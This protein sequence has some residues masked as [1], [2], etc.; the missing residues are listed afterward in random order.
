M[1]VSNTN[2]WRGIIDTLAPRLT[3]TGAA[4]G[5]QLDSETNT[6]RYEI[7][8]VCRAE[9]WSLLEESFDCPG[10]AI[11]PAERTFNNDSI[12]QAQFPELTLLTTM[13]NSYTVWAEDPTPNGT[14]TACDVM[15][16]CATVNVQATA[17]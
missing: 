7:R 1:F 5:Q 14:L 9:D 11:Q 10:N 12:L 6:Q 2:A 3:M 15:D 4:T 13:V 16:H 17:S 8:Y